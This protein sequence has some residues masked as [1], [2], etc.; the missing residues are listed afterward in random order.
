MCGDIEPNPGPVH[1][2]DVLHLNVRSIRNKIQNLLYLAPDFDI[3]CFTKFHLDSNVLDRDITIDGFGTIFRK[4]RN[5]SEGRVLLYVSDLLKV[6]IRSDLEPTDTECI[7]IEIYNPTFNIFLCC[8]YRP[9]SSNSSFW[10]HIANSL[11]KVSDISNQIILI[12]DLNVDFLKI[13]RSHKVNE[14]LLKILFD[15]HYSRGNK[16][17]IKHIQTH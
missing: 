15:Q 2:L 1:T 14:I 5:S 11:E 8:T 16:N 3:L 7:W 9:P 12:G 4:D 10:N 13:T 6:V 17:H